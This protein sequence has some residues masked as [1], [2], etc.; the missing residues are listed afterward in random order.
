MKRMRILKVGIAACGG[1]FVEDGCGLTHIVFVVAC[2]R[3]AL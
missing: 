2:F 1:V 3:E